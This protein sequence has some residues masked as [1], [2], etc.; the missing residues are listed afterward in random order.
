MGY[1]SKTAIE[2]APLQITNCI[3]MKRI[4]FILCMGFLLLVTIS[5]NAQ[6]K[7]AEREIPKL[8][9]KQAFD[10][11]AAKNALAKGTTTLKGTVAIQ[12]VHY[13][14][15]RGKFINVELYPCTPYYEE[16]YSLKKKENLR[17]KKIVGMD[18]L[19]YEHRIYC[20][21][22]SEGDFTF[23]NMKPGK[24][25]LYSVI[26]WQRARR[27]WNAGEYASERIPVH[28]IIEIK[29]GQETVKVKL[30]GTIAVSLR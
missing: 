6:Y 19:A 8:M 20:K 22:N 21:T 25:I 7:Q 4:T 2:L 11:V 5:A 14:K 13:G 23:P 27:G 3:K 1:Y 17:K 15:V 10:A 24:Y 29:P 16:W 18:S 30:G 28:K 9:P 26:H 12:P